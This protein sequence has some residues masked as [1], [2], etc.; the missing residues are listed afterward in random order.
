[1]HAMLFD[2][3]G[4]PLRAS[5]VS[6]TVNAAATSRTNGRP[7]SV[8]ATWPPETSTRPSRANGA[9]APSSD[10]KSRPGAAAARSIARSHISRS[11]MLPR[12]RSSTVSARPLPVANEPAATAR[13]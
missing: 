12:M 1:M 8:T 11:M 3:P 7:R 6:V 4:A 10:A 2:R 9:S 13:E 5:V